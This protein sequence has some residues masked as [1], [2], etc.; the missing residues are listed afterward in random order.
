MY[1]I[2]EKALDD[3]MAMCDVVEEKYTIAKDEFIN[4]MEE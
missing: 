2:L 3:L 4:R 1:D